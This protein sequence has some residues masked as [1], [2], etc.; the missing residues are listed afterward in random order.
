MGGVSV[1]IVHDD[2][3]LPHFPDPGGLRGELDLQ[4]RHGG[5]FA[6]EAPQLAP[7]FVCRGGDPSGLPGALGSHRHPLQPLL[8]GAGRRVPLL[9]GFTHGAEQRQDAHQPVWGH[10][11]VFGACA[12]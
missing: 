11:S 9:H 4:E 1:G 3:H 12:T 5:G 6:R 10:G 8:C 7:G 2:G